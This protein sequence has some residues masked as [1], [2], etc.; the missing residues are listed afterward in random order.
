MEFNSDGSIKLPGNLQKLKDEK[1][2]KLKSQKCIK[3]TKEMV[4]FTSPKKCVLN[5][6]L[7]ESITDSAFI[8]GI[9]RSL[10]G[11]TPTKLIEIG[12]REFKIEIGT[13]FKRC[14]DCNNLIRKYREFLYGN[15]IEE[16]GTCGYKGYEKEFLYED[17]FSGNDSG[18]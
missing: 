12:P 5:I 7:S 14:S 8:E 15:I 18:E 11:P 4:S 2:Q 9:R 1:E 3:I 16:K 13:D 10:E 17:Y 6:V